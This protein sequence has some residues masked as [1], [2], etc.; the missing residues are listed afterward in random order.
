[1]LMF[2]MARSMM[3]S[4]S[5]KA[6]DPATAFRMASA[7]RGCARNSAMA[8]SAAR[9]L[10]VARAQRA[11]LPSAITR[12]RKTGVATQRPRDGKSYQKSPP[13]SLQLFRRR[14]FPQRL[15]ARYAADPEGFVNVEATLRTRPAAFD[16]PGTPNVHNRKEGSPAL[17]AAVDLRAT[18]AGSPPVYAQGQLNS[19]A[20][21]VLAALL[22]HDMRKRDAAS[23]FEPSRLFLYYNERHLRRQIGQARYGHR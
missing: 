4:L 15:C 21:Q 5:S 10:P 13:N 7:K 17:P 18:E 23:A 11:S 20:A 1:M 14:G 22:Y 3:G 9:S 8:V 2:F 16:V 12:S 6:S 19:C